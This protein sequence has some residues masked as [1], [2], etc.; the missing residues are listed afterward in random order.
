MTNT[1]VNH[2]NDV[3]SK[4][5]FDINTCVEIDKEYIVFVFAEACFSAGFAAFSVCFL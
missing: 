2:F 1:I 5:Q 3:L 4:S